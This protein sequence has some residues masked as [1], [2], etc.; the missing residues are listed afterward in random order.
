MLGCFV[1][2]GLWAGVV[3]ALETGNLH[4]AQTGPSLSILL[5]SL[6]NQGI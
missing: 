4:V 3:L 5:S 1:G 2:F 6:P